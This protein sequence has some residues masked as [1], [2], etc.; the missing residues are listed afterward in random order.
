MKMFNEIT[1][2]ALCSIIAILITIEAGR[3][4][5]SKKD[6]N[7]ESDIKNIKSLSQ[8]TNT[9]V[10][11]IEKDLYETKSD[12]AGLKTDVEWLKRK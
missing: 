4:V 3:A 6:G 8:D 10:D 2:P 12:I 9:K 11:K 5:K 7:M 1:I